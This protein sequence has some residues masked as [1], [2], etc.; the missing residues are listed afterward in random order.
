MAAL[1][2]D[3]AADAYRRYPGEAV[4][5]LA[6]VTAAA[7]APAGFRLQLG[8][9]EGLRPGDAHA[10]DN[11]AGPPPDFAQA[12]EARYVLWDLARAVA[13]GECFEFRV[14]CVVAPTEQNLELE[15]TALLAE[16]AGAAEP[17]RLTSRAL[18]V[19]VAAQGRYIKHLPALYQES[20]EF[21]GRFLMLFESFWAP[22]VE[23]IDQIPSYFDPGTA[24]PDLLPW[25]ATWV[26]LTLDERWP[27]AKRRRLLRAAVSLYR[28]RGTRAGLQ[29]YLEIFADRRPRIVEHGGQNFRLGAGGRLGRELALGTAN[30]P[31]T[32]TVVLP[33]P[34]ETAADPRAA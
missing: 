22:I 10:S 26:N 7:A 17:E 13:A 16:R 30:Q 9:P 6:R 1:D 33:L 15:S 5:L 14:H 31:H 27:E 3:L 32:F 21:M 23:R 25:L 28:R 4:I 18:S 12:G 24:P 20:D 8:L 11:Y 2:L 19:A 29:D 34:A